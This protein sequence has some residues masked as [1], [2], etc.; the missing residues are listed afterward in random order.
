MLN[1]IYT[2][3]PKHEA[4]IVFIIIIIIGM[5]LLFNAIMESWVE[6]KLYGRNTFVCLLSGH[7]YHF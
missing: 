7:Q 4:G 1:V 3:Y 5:G 6:P 2:R